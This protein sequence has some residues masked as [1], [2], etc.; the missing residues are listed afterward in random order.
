MRAQTTPNSA[1]EF[2]T[3]QKTMSAI[4]T[5]CLLEKINLFGRGLLYILLFEHL[6]VHCSFG[7]QQSRRRFA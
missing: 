2:L 4:Y 7:L 1:R 3:K 5:H 6:L